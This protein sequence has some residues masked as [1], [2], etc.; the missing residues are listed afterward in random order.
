M[1]W[2]WRADSG[3]FKAEYAAVVMLVAVVTAAVVTMGIPTD[4]SALYDTALCRVAGDDDCPTGADDGPAGDPAD[5]APDPTDGATGS[6]T[7]GAT[8]P[9]PDPSASDGAEEPESVFNDPMIDPDVAAAD[10]EFR[11]AEDAHAAAQADYD[12]LDDELLSLLGEILG[13]EDARKCLTEG[14]LMACLWTVV[15]LAPWGK[16]A[17]LVSKSPK[18][19]RLWNRWRRAGSTLDSAQERLDNASAARSRL[20]RQCEANSFTADTPVLMADGTR[21]PIAEVEIGD[22]V[23]AT[24][25]ATGATGPREVTALITGTGRK[26]LVHLTVNAGGRTAGVVTATADHPFWDAGAGAWTTA[27]DLR[28]GD[29]LR[30]PDGGRATVAAAS[31][32]TVPTTVHNLSV[33]DPHTYYVAVGGAELLTH[34]AGPGCGDIWMDPHRV[35]HHFKHAADFGVTGK[36]GKQTRQEYIEALGHFMRSP[37]NTKI[38]GTFRGQPAHHYVDPDTGQHV[39]VAADGPEVGKVLGAWKSDPGTDQLEYLLRDGVL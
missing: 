25:P 2:V 6:A 37:N 35:E 4:V 9:S 11:D 3:A 26:D 30:T 15:G 12:G 29:L 13:I 5:P 39:S 34:N 1:R 24:D 36:W 17:K 38:T 28:S 33:G 10:Q 7:E 16:G 23:L 32:V 19:L 20:L 31:P 21:L 14:D 8:D 27:G 18:I 22:D